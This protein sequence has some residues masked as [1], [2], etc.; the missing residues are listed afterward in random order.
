MDYKKIKKL[1]S[2]KLLLI[3]FAIFPFGQIDKLI[4]SLLGVNIP[5]HLID[6]FVFLFVILNRPVL[7][8]KVKSFFVVL[9]FSWALSFLAIQN[10]AIYPGVFYLLRFFVYMSFGFSC[11]RFD[12]KKIDLSKTL[13]L[14]GFVI[15]IAGLLQYF[16]IPDIRELKI[17]GWDDHYFR[18]VSTF[19]DPAFTGILLVLS[20]FIFLASKLSRKKSNYIFLGLVLLALLLT[21]SR[22]SFI[23]LVVGGFV[24]FSFKKSKLFLVLGI[25]FIFLIP[26]LPHKSSEGANLLRT[27]SIQLK[28]VNY[29]ESFQIISRNPVFGVGFNNICFYREKDLNSHSC[30]GLDNSFLFMLATTGV[31]GTIAFCDIFFS[32][33]KNLSKK[34]KPLIWSSFAVILL[35][36]MFTNTLFYPYIILWMGLLISEAYKE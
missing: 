27:K 15:A 21:Y 4:F 11:Y 25:L 23:A 10:Y 35:H 20:I 24:Y 7:P 8:R 12:R 36:S 31:L 28:I 18:L 9:L 6:V 2:C 19:L 14:L 32:G 33:L 34:R 30:S 29:K 17:L 26:L 13:F 3:I 5:L 16:L 22:A 1:I